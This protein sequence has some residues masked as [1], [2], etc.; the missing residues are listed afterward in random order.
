MEGIK[1]AETKKGNFYERSGRRINGYLGI[2]L[3]NCVLKVFKAMC[4]SGISVMG[5]SKNCF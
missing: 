4:P 5:I 3:Q 2:W 1:E